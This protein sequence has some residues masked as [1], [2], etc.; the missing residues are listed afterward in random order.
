MDGSLIK[1]GRIKDNTKKSGDALEHKQTK[2]S[3]AIERN[4]RYQALSLDDKIKRNSTKV[5]NKLNKG[6]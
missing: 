6:V 2:R 3:E 1:N 5:I 4:K